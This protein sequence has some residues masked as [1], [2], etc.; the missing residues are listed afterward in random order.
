MPWHGTATL[1]VQ[2]AL[3]AFFQSLSYSRM[4]AHDFRVLHITSR[5]IFLEEKVILI[6]V[7]VKRRI[8]SHLGILSGTEFRGDLDQVH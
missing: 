3:R 4:F 5:R 6:D 7:S 8:Y 2:S 1:R